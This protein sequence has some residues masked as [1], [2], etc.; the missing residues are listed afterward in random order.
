[1]K[2]FIFQIPRRVEIGF[3]K[4][5][6]IARFVREL[7]LERILIVVDRT[8]KELGLLD[9]IQSNL[10]EEKISF[11][12]F[13]E[14]K[15]EPTIAQIDQAIARLDVAANFQGI[16]GIGG[17]STIDVVKILAV[18][19]GI[20]GS[21][22]EYVGTN[23]INKPGVPTIMI[24]TTAGTGAEATPNA[25]FK[26]EVDE[27][28][29][30]VVSP[31]LIPH[32]AVL[33][34]DMTLG[35][36]PKVTAETGLDAFTHA[37]ECF[38]CNKANAMSDLFTLE[39]MRLVSAYLRRAV[40]DGSDKEARY[41][42]LLASFYGGV[43]ITNSGTGGVHALAYPL[44]GKYG[45]S[46][47]LSN[48]VLLAAVMEYNAAAVPQRFVQVAKAMGLKTDTFSER[49]AV[50][51][52]IDEIRRLVQDVGISVQGFNVTDT[53][54]DDL[55]QSAMT[56]QRLLENNPRPITYETARSIYQK[57]L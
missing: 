42:L 35:L 21:V 26:D 36:P 32:L 19:A 39:A 41:Y 16:V 44:G 55:A 8:I 17:G 24:P 28:K 31:Y 34:P 6:E 11:D 5:R 48:S 22:R 12:I 23:I 52:A 38:I 57:S 40:R 30:G 33:D 10:R 4:S 20:K 54:L 7:G 29:K 27:C 15:G 51:S 1:M 25:I 13:A 46:H 45:L 53:V 14:I 18:S 49:Q 3:G 50:R 37:I 9:S 2:D 47:G 56:V 43:A